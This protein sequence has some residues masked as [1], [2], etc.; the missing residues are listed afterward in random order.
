MKIAAYDRI[1]E[2]R[3]EDPEAKEVFIRV[4]VGPDDGAEKF[5]M[6]RFRV[7]PGGYTPKHAHAWEHEVFV[8]AGQG[9]ALTPEGEKAI[10]AGDVIFVPGGDLHQF[11]NNANADLE[12]LCLI[13]ALS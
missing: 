1:K 4:L 5:H 12:F 7:R 2:N 3:V 13:P 8:L 9:I 6:R 11:K 10:T